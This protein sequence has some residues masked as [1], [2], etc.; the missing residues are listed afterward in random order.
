MLWVSNFILGV[1]SSVQLKS[2]DKSWIKKDYEVELFCFKPRHFTEI[3]NT[4]DANNSVG[5][6]YNTKNTCK[7]F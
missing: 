7:A 6:I 3:G 2:S 4:Y 1:G 5:M